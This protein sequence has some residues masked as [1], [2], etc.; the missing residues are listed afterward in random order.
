M[1]SSRGER[2]QIVA[3]RGA[4][5]LRA[6][7]TL[8]AYLQALDDGADALECDVRMTADGHLVCLHDRRIERTSDGRGVVSTLELSQLDALDF[9]SWKD[10]WRDLDDEADDDANSYRVLTLEAL[11]QAVLATGQSVELAIETKHPT[12]YAG[13]VEQRLADLLRRYG[14]TGATPEQSVSARLMSFSWL[15]LRR[16]HELLPTLPTVYLMDRF[17]WRLGDGSLPWGCRA[18]GVAIELIKARPGYVR[19]LQ[20][21]GNLVYVFTVNETVDVNLCL[22]LGVDAIITDHPAHTLSLVLGWDR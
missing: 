3:H 6:E 22:N 18:G 1:S 10:P 21:R 7:H 12:R 11:L 16:M 13:A 9:G 5:G 20:R 19:R 14:L 2:P 8:A 17:Q 4:S 15:S